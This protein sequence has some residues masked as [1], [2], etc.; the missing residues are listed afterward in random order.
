MFT[1]SETVQRSEA[2]YSDLMQGSVGVWQPPAVP[3][4]EGV[5]E[6]KSKYQF[7]LLPVSLLCWRVFNWFSSEHLERGRNK[8]EIFP[9]DVKGSWKRRKWVVNRSL[10]RGATLAEVYIGGKEASIKDIHQNSGI[11]RLPLSAF[12]TD[13]YYRILSTYLTASAFP[14]PSDADILSGGPLRISPNLVAISRCLAVKISTEIVDAASSLTHDA[15]VD[16]TPF[17]Q[18]GKL[19]DIFYFPKYHWATKLRQ[20]PECW[21]QIRRLFSIKSLSQNGAYSQSIS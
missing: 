9:R 17:C 4:S 7:T 14:R 2:G 19:V 20:A 13:L 8:S 16:A 3:E 5:T 1:L 11:W 6:W 12:W 10:N 21:W 18:R 15:V